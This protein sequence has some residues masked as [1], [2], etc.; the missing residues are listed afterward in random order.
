[1]ME[2]MKMSEST[3]AG[4][5]R[6]SATK[7]ELQRLANAD[8]IPLGRARG[9][10]LRAPRDTHVAAIGPAGSGKTRGL[11]L[12]AVVSW[13][14]PVVVASP[15]LDILA[16]ALGWRQTVGRCWVFDPADRSGL[17]CLRWS[18]LNRATTW[19]GALATA[20]AMA[21]AAGHWKRGED[22]FFMSSAANAL[23][24]LL[25]AA[26][27]AGLT[28]G[29]VLSWA[30]T[31]ETEEPRILLEEYGNDQDAIGAIDSLKAESESFLSDTLAVVATL[32]LSPWQD[33]KVVERTTGGTWT[34]ADLLAGNNSLFIVG[35]DD[36]LQ[37]MI[38]A[39]LDEVMAELAAAAVRADGRLPRPVLVALDEVVDVGVG[40]G[41]PSWLAKMRQSGTQ[42]V[43]SWHAVYQMR[44]I[45]DRRST[46][47]ILANFS[48]QLWWWSPDWES[49]R[50]LAC[51]C[52]YA[53]VHQVSEILTPNAK[54]PTQTVSTTQ[55][56]ALDLYA[57][58]AQSNPVLIADGVPPV[59]V[60][61]LRA[62]RARSTR[63]RVAIPPDRDRLAREAEADALAAESAKL[64][65]D[66]EDAEDL[67]EKGDHP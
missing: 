45:F 4:P 59:L 58:H 3:E 61:P 14:G 15:K 5:L 2:R 32:L 19:R 6:R 60:A 26:A 67:L 62:D 23:A 49:M 13:E 38:A 52:G 7:A 35:G 29:A 8:G 42:F 27:V 64:P 43:I 31:G 25:H 28:M 63:Q 37:P 51:R 65:P 57:L 53:A 1:M 17:P 44:R 66:D 41:L 40:D 56:D 30:R 55:L 18:P 39:L 24:P 21:S 12:P 20:R 9:L 16:C 22:G 47:E 54:R 34:A 36:I 48:T 46:E 11:V 10:T 50:E 33:D